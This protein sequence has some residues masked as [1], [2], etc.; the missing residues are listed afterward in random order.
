MKFANLET[1]LNLWRSLL[2]FVR[3][4]GQVRFQDDEILPDNFIGEAIAQYE[5]RWDNNMK[6]R[7]ARAWRDIQDQHLANK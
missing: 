1:H 2:I 7:V 4:T 3:G 6:V 5:I